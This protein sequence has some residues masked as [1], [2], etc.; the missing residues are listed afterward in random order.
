MSTIIEIML[1][2]VKTGVGKVSGKPYTLS[3]A[4]C[5]MRNDDGTPSGVGVTILS[6]EVAANA[7]PGLYSCS[8]GLVSSTYG[9]DAGRIVPQITALLPITASQ[10]K[11]V[12]V[13]S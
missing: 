2:D 9:D 7:K 13:T 11:R 5:V 3:E 8:F 6:K 4:H 1:L 10:F 12:A